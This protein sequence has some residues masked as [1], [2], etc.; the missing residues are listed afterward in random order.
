MV[1]AD[2]IVGESAVKLTD[3]EFCFLLFYFHHSLK[4][5]QI[6]PFYIKI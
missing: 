5:T 3:A 2:V 4:K 6:S 1:N